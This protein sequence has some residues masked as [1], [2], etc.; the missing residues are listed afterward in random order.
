MIEKAYSFLFYGMLLDV[1]GRYIYIYIYTVSDLLRED[2]RIW[3]VSTCI[4]QWLIA[5]KQVFKI[6][7]C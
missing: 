6:Y 5:D 4:A 7:I 1:K 3:W 2:T